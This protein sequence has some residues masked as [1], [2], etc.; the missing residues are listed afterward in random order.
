M[1][2]RGRP[3]TDGC[4]FDYLGCPSSGNS[5]PILQCLSSYVYGEA[6]LVSRCQGLYCV[7][8]AHQLLTT[9]LQ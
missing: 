5:L 3:T 1:N 8:V 2:S 6:W 9:R 4:S 7:P